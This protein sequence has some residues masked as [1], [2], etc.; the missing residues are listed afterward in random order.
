VNRPEIIPAAVLWYF[1]QRK[2]EKARGLGG[3]AE[4]PERK[5]P[6]KSNRLFVEKT[7]LGPE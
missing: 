3:G 2:Y 1:L 7:R 5:I 6:D 4:T